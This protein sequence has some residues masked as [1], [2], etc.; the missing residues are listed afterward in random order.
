LI[1]YCE[2]RRW[3]RDAGA[4]L[5]AEHASQLI[6]GTPHVSREVFLEHIDRL[7]HE[8]EEAPRVVSSLRGD[9]PG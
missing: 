4:V 3:A 2:V 6:T 1:A 8:L 9:P 5:L 7:I